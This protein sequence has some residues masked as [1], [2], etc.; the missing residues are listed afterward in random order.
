MKGYSI[1]HWLK[2]IEELKVVDL[3]APKCP[4]NGILCEVKAIGL[5]F[6]DILLVKGQYQ[7]K[8]PF[9][10]TPGAEFAGVIVEVG[11]QAKGFK[12]GDKVFG[13]DAQGLNA[14]AELIP[15]PLSSSFV[16][17]IPEGMS[18][19]EACAIVSPALL[20]PQS[21]LN[22]CF[23]KPMIYP[24]SY[25]AVYQRALLQSNETIL[26]HAAAGGVGITAVQFAKAIGATVIATA[27]S[28]EKL[29]I[30]K[31]EGA[32]YIINYK[33]EKNWAAK[34][35][36]IT[37]ALVKAGKKRWVGADVVYDPVGLI[38]ESTKCIAWNGRLLVVGFA[39]GKI[40]NVPANRLLLKGASLVGV[41]WGGT[42]VQQQERVVE[43][44]K[45]CL[46]LFTKVNPATSKV[47]RPII[48]TDESYV[49]LESI[50]RALAAL[51]ERK[52]Y[53][54]VVVELPNTSAAAKL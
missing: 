29:E 1:N 32:D 42:T 50:P 5:N 24:T 18:F 49:G 31:R 27:S 17:K 12:V 54:K 2:G 40:E 44:W 25:T 16:F 28:D 11:P 9:P 43:T 53:G 48:F 30:C 47:F 51:G 38:N 6:F 46:D 20:S 37:K 19:S 41:Y 33:T 22:F 52:T 21:A 15:V 26:V 14:Y 8:P 35:N 23:Y 7:S 10:F 39:G 34:V 45:G 4:A 3:P 36:E 13:T